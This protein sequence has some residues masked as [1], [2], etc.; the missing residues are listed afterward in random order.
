MNIGRRKRLDENGSELVPTIEEFQ[1][2]CT[3][4]KSTEELSL[5]QS[6]CN[7]YLE[8]MIQEKESEKKEL[9]D[10]FEKDNGEDEEEDTESEEEE[11]NAQETI[12]SN[13]KLLERIKQTIRDKIPNTDAYA[14][15]ERFYFPGEV[16]EEVNPN[17]QFD[18]YTKYNT[19]NVDSFLYDNEEMNEMFGS[20]IISE[21]YC[22]KC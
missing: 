3:K 8:K 9:D 2:W 10:E 12:K 22:E 21:H 7:D 18:G 16:T 5:F 11:E 17:R 20:G 6:F 4:L 15:N 19:L 13:L 14:P 1:K